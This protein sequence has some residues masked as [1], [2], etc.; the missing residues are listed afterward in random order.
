[1]F[2][3][4][5]CLVW[6]RPIPRILNRGKFERAVYRAAIPERDTTRAFKGAGR[7]WLSAAK[8]SGPNASGDG[9][10]ALLSGWR[11]NTKAS[12]RPRKL[13][14]ESGRHK[15]LLPVHNLPSTPPADCNQSNQ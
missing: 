6:Q 13:H 9:L 10:M 7:G 15:H 14:V 12:Q 4:N 11:Q 1:M 5:V 3:T 8:S 2:C